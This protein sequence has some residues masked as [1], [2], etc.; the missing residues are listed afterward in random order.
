MEFRARQMELRDSIRSVVDA[1]EQRAREEEEARRQRDEQQARD[2]RCV[3][4]Q[5]EMGPEVF[6]MALMNPDIFGYVR[7]SL[8]VVCF[9]S[10]LPV[11]ANVE[12]GSR[13]GGRVFV[14]LCGW[15]CLCMIY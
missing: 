7:S 5:V 10:C 14:C 9:A 11:R 15:P 6:C 1:I 2:L 3:P 8:G 12:G 4:E 13:C